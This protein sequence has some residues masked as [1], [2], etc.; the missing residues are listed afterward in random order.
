[1]SFVLD[2]SVAVA[3]FYPEPAFI[4][5][6]KTFGRRIATETA[7]APLILATEVLNVL[8]RAERRRRGADVFLEEQVATLTT[9]NVAYD[10]DTFVVLLNATLPLARRYRLSIFD[11]AYLELA[12]RLSLPLATFDVGLTRAATAASVPLA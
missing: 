3:L 6:T 11:A 9:L 7:V 12:I 2:A 5:A 8:V 1:M 10:A 4:D